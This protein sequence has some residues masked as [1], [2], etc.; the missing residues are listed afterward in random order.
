M[1]F[2]FFVLL[3]FFVIAAAD[4]SYA[5]GV[6]VII[7]SY[8][9]FIVIIP[10][11]NDI[12]GSALPYDNRNAVSDDI[13]VFLTFAICMLKRLDILGNPFRIDVIYGRVESVL[14]DR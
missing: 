3:G 1:I 2:G 5:A 8:M 9:F 4:D 13:A 6:F 10:D 14:R 12:I 11:F 7:D